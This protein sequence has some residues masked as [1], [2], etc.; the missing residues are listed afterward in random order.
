MAH[1]RNKALA[2]SANFDEKEANGEVSVGSMSSRRS[3]EDSIKQ[4]IHLSLRSH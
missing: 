3:A 1:K 4:S 2:T